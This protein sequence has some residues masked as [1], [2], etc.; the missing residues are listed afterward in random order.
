M[1]NFLKSLAG[2]AAPVI[3]GMLGGP[4]G[5][6]AGSALAGTVLGGDKGNKASPQ[7]VG[8]GTS[9]SGF[10][11]LPPEVQQAFLQQYLPRILQQFQ[12]GGTQLAG[13]NPM[14]EQALQS[15]GGGLSGLQ[16]ELPGYQDLYNQNVLDPEL[17]RLQQA[18][19]EGLSA[20]ADRRQKMGGIGVGGSAYNNQRAAYENQINNLRLNAR[21]NAFQGARGLRRETLQDMLTSGGQYQ[22][23]QQAQYNQPQANI[24]QFAGNLAGI[25]TSATNTN[26]GQTPSQPDFLSKLGGAGLGALGLGQQ[27]GWS[28]FGGNN[29]VPQSASLPPQFST[30]SL[31]GGQ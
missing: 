20:L 7:G 17:E 10:A 9:V 23:Q 31:W 24:S 14:Q 2:V 25:P 13:F 28:G 1:A 12:G 4:A 11:A 16:Q 3:G 29:G 5:A 8:G 18:Q 19:D 15:F 21:A 30:G 22:Q 27:M 6:A 26:Y